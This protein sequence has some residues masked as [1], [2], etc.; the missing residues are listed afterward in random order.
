MASPENPQ[1]SSASLSQDMANILITDLLKERRSDRRW[2]WVRRSLFT[3][4]GL[5]FSAIVAY[6]QLSQGGLFESSPSKDVVGIINV[7][8]EIG[9]NSLASAKRLIPL[10]DKAFDDSHVKVI[11][12]NINSPGGSPIE[13]EK[14]NN[15]I[16]LKRKQKNKPVIAIIDQLG[17][18]AAYMIASHADRIYAGRYSLVGSI[19]AIMQGWDFSKALN[20]HNIFRRTY[21]SG[22]LKGLMDPYSK[23]PDGGE[24]KAHTLVTQMGKEF[25]NEV[26]RF[27]GK[28]LSKDRDLFSGEVWGGL[29]AKQLGLIDEVATLDQVVSNHYKMPKHEFGPN[30]A[31]SSVFGF[32]MIGR[33]IAETIIK[34]AGISSESD[35]G[36]KMMWSNQ[37]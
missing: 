16:E 7:S 20:N 8:G 15:Y 2:V 28:K 22:E 24:E 13:S 37:Q 25:A 12:L 21:A 26:V 9:T 1:V 31:K 11:A 34:H 35:N 14:I 19:G 36:V 5:G 30:Q 27:R 6:S 23:M 18:S 33:G 3:A 17:A 29:E 10:L 32:E 4:A